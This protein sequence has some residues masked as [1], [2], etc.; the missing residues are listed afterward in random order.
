M[1]KILVIEDQPASREFLCDLLR[2]RSHE[3]LEAANGRDG[4]DVARRERPDLVVTDILMPTIDGFTFARTLRTE[5]DIADTPIIFLTASYEDR[6]AEKLAEIVGAARLLV[7]PSPPAVILDAVDS[8]LHHSTP[9]RPP[10][11]LPGFDNDHLELVN[12]KLLDKVS[13]LE[14]T[15]ARLDA[16]VRIGLAVATEQ[17][18]QRLFRDLCEKARELVGA[19]YAF[20]EV[21][22]ERGTGVRYG[23]VDG[24]GDDVVARYTPRLPDG[25]ALAR[26]VTDGG[27]VRLT[28]PEADRERA[29]LHPELPPITSLLAVPIL[30]PSRIFGSLCLAD[31]VGFE[32]FGAGDEQLARVLG[33]AAGVA[34]ENLCRY[35]VLK[36]SADRLQ[37]LHEMDSAILGARSAEEIA[38]AA[39]PRIHELIVCDRATVLRF[40]STATRATVLAQSPTATGFHHRTGAVVALADFGDVIP[41][42][43]DL[44]RG[45]ICRVDVA[46]Y[47]KTRG[48][49]DLLARGR[50]YF[51][52]M[53]MIAVDALIGALVLW[54]DRRDALGNEELQIA[55]ELAAQLAVAVHQATQR[56]QIE[57]AEAR[58][59]GLFD[60]V[61]VG[62]FRS[63]PDGT[64]TDLNPAGAEMMGFPSAEKAKGLNARDL[65]LNPEDFQQLTALAERQGVI[66]DFEALLRRPDGNTIWGSTSIRAIRDAQGNVTGFD[67]ISADVTEQ[68]AAEQA[69]RGRERLLDALFQASPAG[70]AVLDLDLRYMRVNEPLAKMNGASIEDHIGRTVREILPETADKVEPLFAKVLATGEPILNAEITGATPSAPGVQRD[71]IASFFP[72]AEQ[73]VR[74]MAIG[75]VVVEVTAVRE[76]ERKLRVALDKAEESDRLKSAFLQN[77]SHEVRTP[78]NV[79]L[80]YNALIGERLAELQ[81]PALDADLKSVGRA[82][83]RLLQTIQ[84]IIDLSRIESA[85]FEVR[86]ERVDLAPLLLEAVAQAREQADRKRLSLTCEI[87]TRDAK[88]SID[89]YCFRQSF[90][91]L[92]DNAIKF[93]E[94][95]GVAVRLFRDE[96]GVLCV[97]IRDTGIGIDP[98][99]LPHLF[100]PF[101]QEDP[102]HTRRFEGPGIGLALAKRYL[103]LNQAEIFVES[104]KGVGSTCTMRFA[105]SKT[106]QPAGAAAAPTAAAAKHPTVKRGKKPIVLLVEDDELTQTLVATILRR[107]FDT[108]VAATGAEARAHLEAHGG[109][110]T[111]VLMDLSLKGAEDGLMLTRS[112]RRDPRWE[113]LPVIATTAHALPEDRQRALEAGCTA[114]LAKPITRQDLY[115]AIRSVSGR[116]SA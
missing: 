58:Y 95:G 12:A 62:V 90:V 51:V 57:E 80:G 34:Y 64:I 4:L 52:I 13:Q 108:L 23:F 111:V 107:D 17:N 115:A 97:S 43:A 100:Q 112:M 44:R 73:D 27:S 103:A 106:P 55:S 92:L 56:K 47:A 60:H 36:R 74:P 22:D 72:I 7:K 19:K 10:S 33:A 88:L 66:T 87:E 94:R 11:P 54:V 30:T 32:G 82:S 1:A 105:S 86:S 45:R 96:Q 63:L 91:R 42:V 98:N 83:H 70:I 104:Q 78:L 89:E 77:M 67:G 9:R 61:P 102:S 8:A 53:P 3:V 28:E 41:L 81:D 24:V 93:T 16:L 114:F 109:E 37:L 84:G 71:W 39:V 49:A 76:A 15:T 35:E 101:S 21:R 99:Y 59:H 29:Q 2:S 113:S 6:E 50:R 5:K 14:R 38:Q 26:L 79:I 85:T 18:P 116:R 75:A 68:K 46:R 65:Y 20:V 69:L 48:T 31:R 110:I 40:D 25:G